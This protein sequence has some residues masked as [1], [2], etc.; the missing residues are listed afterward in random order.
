MQP[1]NNTKSFGPVPVEANPPLVLESPSTNDAAP[2]ATVDHP[3][4]SARA[5][6]DYV[7][8]AGRTYADSRRIIIPGYELLGV[9]GKGGMGVVY[10]ARQ[11]KADRIVALKLMLHADHAD[12][13]ARER[14]AIEAQAVARLQHP[15]IVQVFE[16][17]EVD[18]APFF[19]LEYVPGGTLSMKI[20]D[21]LLPPKASAEILRHPQSGH[22][23]CP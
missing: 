6:V 13:T 9:L 11:I 3:P 7:P 17:G 19:T 4:V 22:G 18:G 12:S 1:S 21:S 5:T 10:K 8:D 20:K 16:V 15:N 2:G 23:L 14:F